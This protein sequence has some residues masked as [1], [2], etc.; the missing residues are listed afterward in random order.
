MKMKLKYQL[1]VGIFAIFL[2]GIG[3][4]IGFNSV[5]D[6]NS[7]SNNNT[8][9]DSNKNIEEEKNVSDT[10]V[11]KKYDIEL[12]YIDHYSLCGEDIENTKTVYDTTIDELKDVEKK[13]QDENNLVYEIKE[14][15][16]EKLVYYR[17]LNRNCPNHFIAKIEDDVVVIYNN[18]SD[19]VTEE[20]RRLED[21]A[22]SLIREDLKKELENGIK[23]DN[24]KSLELLIEDLES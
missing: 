6:K 17:K 4:Y 16:R 21:V 2:M 12:T 22:V 9:I 19:G 14:Q 10:V 11:T 15:S 3:V 13:Y 7:A 1:L 24:I 18:V 20:Y 23:I 8:D 5:S